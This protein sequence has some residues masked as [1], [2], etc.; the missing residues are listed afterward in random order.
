MPAPPDDPIAALAAAA[1]GLMVPSEQDAPLTPF[2]LPGRGPL[3]PARL[4]A[5]LGLPP[6]TPVETR[7]LDSFFAPLTRMRPAQ[8]AAERAQTARFAT[9]AEQLVARL[10]DPA[11]FRVGNV[12]VT[13]LLLGRLPDGRV[14]G[15]RTLLVET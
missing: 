4:L 12:E 8:D 5:A 2:V 6:G 13:V 7:S 15:L 14:G 11:V 3:T 10:T 1:A 9:L